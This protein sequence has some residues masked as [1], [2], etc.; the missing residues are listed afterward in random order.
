MQPAEGRSRP[1]NQ[2]EAKTLQ[3]IRR[4]DVKK[5]SKIGSRAFFMAA[6]GRLSDIAAENLVGLGFRAPTSPARKL[7][8][9]RRACKQRP[10]AETLELHRGLG[11]VAFP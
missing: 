11:S 3:H 5:L 9:L 8:C 10:Q 7:G 2:A 6:A 4:V 1:P